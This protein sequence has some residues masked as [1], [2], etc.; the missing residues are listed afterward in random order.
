MKQAEVFRYEEWFVTNLVRDEEGPRGRGA[1]ARNMRDGSMEIF[2]AKTVILAAGG[3][4]QIYKPTTNALICTG[5]G[6]AMAYRLG[7]TLMDMEMVQYHP[8]HTPGQRPA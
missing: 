5:D 3:N 2:Q 7:A 4:G 6:I 8:H 1:V